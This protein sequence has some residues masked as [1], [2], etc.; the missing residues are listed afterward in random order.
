MDDEVLRLRAEAQSCYVRL[1]TAKGEDRQRLLKR[2]AGL[3]EEAERSARA[4]AQERVGP[5]GRGS[6]PAPTPRR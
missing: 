6:S 5:V 1:E 4:R 3:W 2:I